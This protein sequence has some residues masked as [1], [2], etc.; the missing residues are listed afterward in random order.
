MKTAY[1]ATAFVLGESIN[2]L[3][4]VKALGRQGVPT[5]LIQSLPD[6]VSGASRFATAF[7]APDPIE[8]TE[9]YLQY[10]ESLQD[11]LGTPGVL[12]PTTDVTVMVISQHRERLA[13]RFKFV[14]PPHEVIQKVTSKEGFYE[15][16]LQYQLPVPRTFAAESVEDVQRVIDQLEFPCAIKPY[17]SHVWRSP[18]FRR[19]FGRIQI[20]KV[21]TPEALLNAYRQFAVYDSRMVIQ[22]FI[23][24]DDDCEYSLHTYTSRDGQTMINFLAHK[25]RLD[26]IHHG[27]AAFIETAHDGE[28]FRMGNAF[29]RHLGYRGM[30]SFQFKWDPVR[31]KYFAIELN[32]RFSLWNYLEPSCGVNYPF[33]NYLDSLGEP[34][35]IPPDYPDGVKWFSIERDLSAFLA[36]RRE[37]SLTFWQW[38]RS[39]R[40]P[41][42]CAE[43]SWDDPAPFFQFLRKMS[44]RAWN[45][46]IKRFR[47][48]FR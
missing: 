23:Q 22:E 31:E 28:I 25:I 26:P 2:A 12:L 4:V 35:D 9:A 46:L 37:G 13:R 40:G 16:A 41:K 17:Y 5:Y 36:Y 3:G 10:L 38:I 34:F 6:P 8:Q 45:A 47:K 24:G 19:R 20:V 27:S 15:L 11:G 7:Q 30:S 21:D 33:I 42:V 29:L 18:E 1:S 14:I 48:L 44:K 32:P 43:F 39:Y